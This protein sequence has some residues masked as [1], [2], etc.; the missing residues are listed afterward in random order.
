MDRS[1]PLFCETHCPRSHTELHQFRPVAVNEYAPYI[2]PWVL[3]EC[4]VCGFRRFRSLE[5]DA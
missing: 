5:D 1:K 4:V 2:R 3:E